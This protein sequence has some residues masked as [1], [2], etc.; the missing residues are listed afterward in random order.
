METPNFETEFLPETRFT[1]AKKEWDS[2]LG[3]ATIQAYNWRLAAFVS[4][5]INICA[6]IGI[7]MI[8]MRIEVIP[9]VVEVGDRGQVQSLGR[10][11]RDS[12]TPTQAIIKRELSEWI[13]N[14]RGISSDAVVMQSNFLSAYSYVTTKGRNQ[15]NAYATTEKPFELIGKRIV[16]VD[17]ISVITVNQNRAYQL[18]WKEAVFGNKGDLMGS[19]QYQGILSIKI[20]QPKTEEELQKNPFGIRVD[21]FNW[22]E[23]APAAIE[24]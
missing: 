20:V 6:V 10:L 4:L 18:N 23:I 24:K 17:I 12:Y 8:A 3:T 9:Y 11:S 22:Q 7:T 1:R 14:I 5:I 19:K 2:R 15:L 13:S 16:A 21:E